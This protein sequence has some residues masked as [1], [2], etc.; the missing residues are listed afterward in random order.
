MKPEEYFELI[1]RLNSIETSLKIIKQHLL[2]CREVKDKSKEANNE[3]KQANMD[4]F[5]GKFVDGKLVS[6]GL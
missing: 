4:C 5:I 3:S 2:A 1:G 6:V